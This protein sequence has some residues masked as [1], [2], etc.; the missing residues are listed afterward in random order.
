M[1][2][3]AAR[4]SLVVALVITTCIAALGQPQRAAASHLPP[5]AEIVV[6]PGDLP[7][8]LEPVDEAG[9]AS[10]LPDGLARP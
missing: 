8:G 10:W 7:P 9:T 5:P 3:H 6:R 2:Q 4:L 1:K